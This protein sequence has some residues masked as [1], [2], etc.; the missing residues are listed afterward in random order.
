M[1]VFFSGVL[2]QFGFCAALAV[3]LTAAAFLA[4]PESVGATPPARRTPAPDFSGARA[5]G[6]GSSG[7]SARRPHEPE[8]NGGV[9]PESESGSFEL[10]EEA[11][12][13]ANW[14]DPVKSKK[15]RAEVLEAAKEYRK[16]W[17]SFPAVDQAKV[18]SL[19]IRAIK[20]GHVVFYTDLPENPDVDGIPDALEAAIPLVCEFFHI[21]PS[22]FD[23]W[24][25]EAFLMGDWK[26]FIEIRALNGPPEF[27]YGYSMGDRIF[28]KDQ[29]SAYYNR[30]LLTHELVHTLMHEIF[31]DLRPRWYSEGSAEYVALHRWDPKRKRMEL[32]IIPESEEETPGFGRLRQI[33]EIL[34][35]NRAPTLYDILHFRPRNFVDVS[36]YSWSWAFVMFLYN[37]PKYKEI[38]EVLPYWSIT[39]DPNRLFID[40]IGERWGELEN[41]WADFIDRIDYRYDF[42]ATVIGDASVMAP[43]AEVGEGA[44]VEID[45]SRGWQNTGLKLDA[46][47]SYKLTAVGRYDF[48]LAAA[49]RALEFEPTG[50]SFQ[51]VHGAPIGRLEAVVVPEITEFTF[52]QVYGL[53]AGAL[54]SRNPSGADGFRFDAFRGFPGGSTRNRF[55][56]Q[57]D[58][59]D[60]SDETQDAQF[61]ARQRDRAPERSPRNRADAAAGA[62]APLYNARY[63]WNESIGFS[64]PTATL[65]PKTGGTLYMRINAPPG[66][67]GRNRGTAR[68]QI[69][70]G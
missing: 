54:G 61:A 5:P 38:A 8:E 21:D 63:P 45:A 12:D 43:S 50:A 34:K 2:R 53:G 49:G 56:E 69:K 19:E 60:R 11:N 52:D 58:G 66:D 62:L 47:A 31:G 32:A 36:T 68:V 3:F 28:A 41:D 39:D 16:D 59:F 22:R 30:F 6:D 70:R 29:K 42:D 24:Q 48:Y 13:A 57:S 44:V 14:L 51:Y 23:N 1:N 18:K 55:G 15:L 64:S 4:Q 10:S 46:G 26:P 33:R 9:L 27:L 7:P 67:V 25:V 20:T 37:S 65:T 40:A 35:T 17:P